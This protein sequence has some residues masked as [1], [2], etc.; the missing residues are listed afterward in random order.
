MEI[1]F[2]LPRFRDLLF[3]G[4]VLCIQM[5]IFFVG[6]FFL[7]S[8]YYPDPSIFVPGEISRSHLFEFAIFLCSSII[9]FWISRWKIKMAIALFATEISVLLFVQ[10]LSNL[11]GYECTTLISLSHFPELSIPKCGISSLNPL[12]IWFGVFL[13]TTVLL[14]DFAL[15]QRIKGESLKARH[16]HR[17]VRVTFEKS[18]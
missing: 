1:R 4:L 17:I 14:W 9:A 18:V 10:L 5:G 11:W 16:S 8:F 12:S 15:Q 3:E 2:S 13:M 7:F 6:V